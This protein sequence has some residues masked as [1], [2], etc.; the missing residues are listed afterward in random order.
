L[1]GA[2]LLG[3]LCDLCELLFQRFWFRPGRD[4]FSVA[5]GVFVIN[6]GEAPV[7]WHIANLPFFDCFRAV[8]NPFIDRFSRFFTVF[9][10]F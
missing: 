2:G 3:S 5:R 6:A 7:E 10:V 4:R 8:F 1:N 9:T